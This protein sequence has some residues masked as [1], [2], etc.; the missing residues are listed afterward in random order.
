MKQKTYSRANKLFLILSL[1]FTFVHPISADEDSR[2]ELE[3]MHVTINAASYKNCKFIEKETIKG[4]EYIKGKA[5]SYNKDGEANAGILLQPCA[6]YAIKTKFPGGTYNITVFYAIDKEKAPESPQISIGI[7]TQKAQHIEIKNKLINSVKASFKVNFFK[8]KNHT[9]KVWFPSEG[10][11][12]RE[13]R[14]NRALINKKQE[15]K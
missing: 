9:V 2:H 4:K 3:N 11:K 10:V 6:E 7:N 5:S 1:L 15:E 13:I 12:I 8:G 14:I